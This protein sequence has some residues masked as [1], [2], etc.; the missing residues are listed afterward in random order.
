MLLWLEDVDVAVVLDD[1]AVEVELFADAAA[2]AL[3]L[4]SQVVQHW[5]D[6]LLFFF[7]NRNRCR[8]LGGWSV[9]TTCM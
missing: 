9:D 1:D 4:P 6:N 5:V 7:P 2:E 3:V 8:F